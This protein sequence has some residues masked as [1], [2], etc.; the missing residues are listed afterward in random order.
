MMRRFSVLAAMILTLMS[1]TI[2][3]SSTANAII[4]GYTAAHLRGQV[5]IWINANYQCAGT[6]IGSNWVL[7]AKHCFDGG[8]NVLN[9]AVYAGSREI[10]SGAR[11]TVAGIY[12][13]PN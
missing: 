4:G 2:F 8:G 9:T 5:Q 11:M 10:G 13:H 1:T 6:L 7:T 3:T 12:R